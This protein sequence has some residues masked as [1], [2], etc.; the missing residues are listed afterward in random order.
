MNELNTTNIIG[1]FCVTIFL[2]TYTSTHL[3]SIIKKGISAISRILHFWAPVTETVHGRWQFNSNMSMNMSASGTVWL[4]D[5]NF[6]YYTQQGRS[7]A[8][9]NHLYQAQVTQVITVSTVNSA[10]VLLWISW[11]IKKYRPSSDSSFKDK[12]ICC[13]VIGFPLATASWE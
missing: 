10:L 7:V 5:M 11:H 3:C 2:L 12:V 6:R 13:P 9:R 4:T 8:Q 1:D